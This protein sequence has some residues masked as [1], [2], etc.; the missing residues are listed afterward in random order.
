MNDDEFELNLKIDMQLDKE[1]KKLCREMVKCW[2]LGHC[3]KDNK[4]LFQLFYL[5][6]KKSDLVL[7][8]HTARECA[9]IQNRILKESL[10]IKKEYKENHI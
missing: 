6:I 4:E 2:S 3:K 1:V 9:L 10:K 5:Y 7:E 8:L